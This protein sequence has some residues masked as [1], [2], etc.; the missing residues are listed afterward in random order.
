M[1]LDINIYR[2]L[3]KLVNKEDGRIEIEEWDLGE[4][5]LGLLFDFDLMWR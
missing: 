1:G 2:V 3:D 4:F 5:F